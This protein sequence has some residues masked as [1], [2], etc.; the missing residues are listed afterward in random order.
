MGAAAITRRLPKR[1]ALAAAR[2]AKQVLNDFFDHGFPKRSRIRHARSLAICRNAG[3]GLVTTGTCTFSSRGKS[4]VE[5][6]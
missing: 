3:P 1:P 5:S 2:F 4:L 6:L